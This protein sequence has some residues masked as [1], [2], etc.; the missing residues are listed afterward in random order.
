MKSNKLWSWLVLFLLLGVMSIAMAAEPLGVAAQT[1]TDVSEVTLSAPDGM[2]IEN[3]GSSTLANVT[4]ANLP[5]GTAFDMCFTVYVQSPDAEYMDHF[6]ADLPDGWTVNSVA[7]NSV[8]VAQGCSG[9]LPP[10][11]GVDAGNVVYWQS[12]GYPP[13]TGCGAWNGGSAGTNFD[14]CTNITIPDT[15]GAPWL[16]PWYYVGDGY[17]GTPHEV[18]GSYG[19]IE[20]VAPFVMTPDVIEEDGCACGLQ[21]HMLTVFNTTGSDVL[22]NLS[23]TIVSGAGSCSGPAAISVPNGGSTAFT[24]DF[25]PAGLPGD[26]VACE[27]VAVDNADPNNNDTSALIKHLISYGFDPAGWQLEPI[28]AATPNQWAGSTVGTNPLAAGPVGYVVGGLAA[29]SSV[30]NP[31]LQMYDPD[32]GTWTQLADLPNPRFSPVVGWIGGLLYAAGGYDTAFVATNDLQVY[33]PVAG[34]WDNT[35]PADMPFNRGGGAG[36]VGICSSGVGTVP[37]PRWRRSRRQFFHHNPGDVA[38]RPRHR[39]MDAIG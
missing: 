39:R 32:T 33:D 34:T 18:S 17:G 30:I 35:T 7:P 19:P 6:D 15:T 21:E 16:L 23:Y 37:L 38:V 12:T 25:I 11:V 20:P 8:P 13:Q 22:V 27:V 28:T 31:D 14:F 4:P 1:P 36:G 9:A 29:G 24:V 26:T 10:V 3:V 5:I 2:G